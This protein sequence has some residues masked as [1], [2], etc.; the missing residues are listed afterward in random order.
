MALTPKIELRQS[1]TLVMTPQ[2]QQAIKLLQLSNVELSAFLEEELE[3]NPLL[4]RSEG[5]GHDDIAA[6]NPDRDI[7]TD[8]GSR[9]GEE[10][11]VVDSAE[12]ADRDILPGAEDAPLDLD[13]ETTFTSDGHDEAPIAADPTEPLSSNWSSPTGGGDYSGTDSIIERTASESVG[14]KEHLLSQLN[15]AVSTRSTGSL[16]AP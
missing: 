11:H 6:D 7:T 5:E 13:Y 3:R 10:A 4:E 12:L 14:L 8:D 2:L 16:V 15:I 9:D 1:Q